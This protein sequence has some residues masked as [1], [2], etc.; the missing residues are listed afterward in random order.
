[1]YRFGATGLE[2]FLVH[3]GGPFYAKKDHGAWGLPKGEYTPDEGPLAAAQREFHEETG[4]TATPPFHALGKIRQRS[5]K[6]VTAWAFQG[7][8]D[9]ALLESNLCQVE[10]PPRSGRLIDIPEVD[11]G[12]WFSLAEAAERIVESQQPLLTTLADLLH[13]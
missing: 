12:A 3:P 4:F 8:C 11:R 10:W 13:D 7:D 5:G 9:P 6:I 1:M 2:V